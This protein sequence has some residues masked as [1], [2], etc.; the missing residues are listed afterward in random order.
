MRYLIVCWK[1]K[2]CL[3]L[4]CNK[5]LQKIIMLQNENNKVSIKMFEKF[6]SI[7]LFSIQK[8]VFEMSD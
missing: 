6:V 5:I 1:I 7:K 8:E 3:Y 4:K 2:R